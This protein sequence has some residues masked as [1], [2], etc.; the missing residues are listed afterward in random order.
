MSQD[1]EGSKDCLRLVQANKDS[2]PHLT[3]QSLTH[4]SFYSVAAGVHSFLRGSTWKSDVNTAR[5]SFPLG[6]YQ[7]F[8]PFESLDRQP[9]GTLPFC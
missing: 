4:E 9:R 1:T 2:P 8:A 3:P 5:T 6:A 7:M